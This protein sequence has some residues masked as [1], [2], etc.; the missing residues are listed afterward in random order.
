MMGLD[1][2]TKK[3]LTPESWVWAIVQN[4]GSNESFLGQ[5]DATNDIKF[6]PAFYD[7]DSALRCMNGFS[8]E[9][10]STYEPQAVIL[11]DLL[12]YT[13]KHGFIIFLLDNEGK[14]LEKLSIQSA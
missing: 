9:A 14:I 1:T 10:S 7:K 13:N 2:M 4:P 3:E 12:S 8:K 6:V 11:E 5:Q